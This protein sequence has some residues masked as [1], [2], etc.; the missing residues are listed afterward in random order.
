MKPFREA[1]TWLNIKSMKKPLTHST[2]SWIKTR[3]IRKPFSIGDLFFLKLKNPR[4]P[5]IRSTKSCSS[6]LKTPMPSLGKEF[7][8][9]ILV[10]VKKPLKPMKVPLKF[11][12]ITLKPGI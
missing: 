5:S 3:I 2:K 6:S 1:L 9:Q 4:K 12:R 8:L 10:S 7:V 11:L